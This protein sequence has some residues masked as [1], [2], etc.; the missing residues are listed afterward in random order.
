M[1]NAMIF[2][3]RFLTLLLLFVVTGL[4]QHP[5]PAADPP[6]DWV[7]PETGYRVV[8]L[9]REPG[10]ASLYFHQNAYTASG[11]KLV[12][13]TREGLSVYNFKTQAIEPLVAGHVG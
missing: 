9:S 11:D 1:R 6:L 7:E 10:S 2:I 4:A 13:T 5:P 3:T 8:R 12:W